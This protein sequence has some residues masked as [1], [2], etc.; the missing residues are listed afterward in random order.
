MVFIYQNLNEDLCL[1]DRIKT[2][3]LYMEKTMRQDTI[4]DI[5]LLTI[6]VVSIIVLMWM[7]LLSA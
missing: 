6:G 1:N 5:V 2:G 7:F 4:I 3:Y